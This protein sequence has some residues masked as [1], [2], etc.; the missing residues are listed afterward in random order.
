ML[1]WLPLV[2]P[3]PMAGWLPLPVNGD[4]IG[5]VS[6]KRRGVAYAKDKSS[7]FGLQLSLSSIGF[8]IGKSKGY[9]E[10]LT[11]ASITAA[12]NVSLTSG[13][14]TSLLGGN[15]IGRTV[16]LDVGRDLTILSPQAQGWR[17]GFSFGLTVGVNPADWSVRGSKEDGFKAWSSGSGIVAAQGIDI[18]VAEDT[19]LIGA[20]LQATDGDISLDTGTL[21]VADL[22]DTDQYKNVGGSIGIS[23]GG[24]NSV[25]FSYE[26]KDKQGETRTTL[27]ASGDLNVT[28]RD[29]D[30]DGVAG[31]EADKAAAEQLLASINKDASKYQEITKDDYTKLS[32]ELD[33][34]NLLE[35]GDNLKKIQNY[36]RAQNA[37]IPET[38]A[39]Q[40]PEAVDLYRDAIVR[41]LTGAELQNY[42]AS[43]EFHDQ[44][45]KRNNLSAA[46]ASGEKTK[47]EISQIL[48]LTAAGEQL[49]F[50]KKD[51]QLKIVT[52]CGT[53]G[54]GSS[55]CGVPL[56]ELS[57][58]SPDKVQSFIDSSLVTLLQPQTNI[59]AAIQ[60]ALD[61]AIAWTIQGGSFDAFGYIEN[62]LQTNTSAISVESRYRADAS[63]AVA[64][65]NAI[66]IAKAVDA[67]LIKNL[68][69]ES[70][71]WGSQLYDVA[72][73]AQADP[74]SAWGMISTLQ[75]QLLAM[76]DASDVGGNTWARMI[77]AL[78]A[79]AD[80]LG[81]GDAVA[82]G[83]DRFQQT[84]DE[85]RTRVNRG[86]RAWM[87]GDGSFEK[88]PKQDQEAAQNA[89][90]MATLGT[91]T[92]PGAAI[93]AMIGGAVGKAT[94]WTLGRSQNS[95]QNAYD[96]FKNH[97]N[98]F[99]AKN[100]T[101]Y[102]KMTYEFRDNPPTGSLSKV[103]LNGD[104][105]VYDP[106]S[107]TLGIFDKN[108][109]PKTMYKPMPKSASNPRG[110]D[111][112]KF[113]SPMDYYN[114]Q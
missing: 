65:A 51:N 87:A 93:G 74:D 27:D 55:P 76:G 16:D 71:N 90:G 5:N 72:K 106:A 6:S 39:A 62:Y 77:P 61:C 29:A 69:D 14:D 86:I 83:R 19:T 98:E 23:G 101:Q 45:V 17:D 60:A 43:Q 80:S 47:E 52:D 82:A 53:N 99:N 4:L 67:K 85:E 63:L 28:I 35:F 31:T 22:K 73:I 1:I 34:Q 108:G 110:Y 48:Y 100:A 95:V 75:Y 10:T 18:K 84:S 24:L 102:V 88:L 9:D 70:I 54:Y 64:R 109:A 59:D 12:G 15:I 50:D 92:G 68:N 49:F 41:G 107:N 66:Q 42:V 37:A 114:A 56:N 32:G 7:S 40:G 46:I 79:L 11:N 113:G 111:P 94:I 81:M 30:K 33:V 57:K 112:N 44:L 25:G 97:G 20:L 26:K 104:R 58:L 78:N 96:H 3:A 13:R 8:D 36:Q 89:L 105:I 21:T 103:R 38:V 91:A 2:L